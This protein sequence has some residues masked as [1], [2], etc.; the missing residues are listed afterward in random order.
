MY[1]SNSLDLG[2]MTTVSDVCNVIELS[3]ART[4]LVS[5]WY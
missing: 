5:L 2:C 1:V 4:V 3:E